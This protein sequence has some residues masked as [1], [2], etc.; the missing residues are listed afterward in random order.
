MLLFVDHQNEGQ[1]HNIYAQFPHKMCS[2]V[3][4]N[5]NANAATNPE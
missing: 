3:C 5:G 1:S 4:A 2:N